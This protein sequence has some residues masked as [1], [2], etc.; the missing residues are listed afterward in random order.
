MANGTNGKLPGWAWK[1]LSALAI[2]LFIWVVKLEVDRA[3]I[4]VDVAALQEHAKTSEER[5]Q[6]QD[7]LIKI[8]G[9]RIKTLQAEVKEARGMLTAINANTNALGKLE[10]KIDGVSKNLSEIK[11][12]LRQP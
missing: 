11:T 1:V 2:P 5:S 10:V 12:L 7:S 3:V 8:Q 9:E 6:T 4:D